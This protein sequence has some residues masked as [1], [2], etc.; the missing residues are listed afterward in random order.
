MD[1]HTREN[2]AVGWRVEGSDVLLRFASF[3]SLK[4][5]CKLYAS[6]VQDRL[7]LFRG[8]RRV[9]VSVESRSSVCPNWYEVVLIARELVA[10]RPWSQQAVLPHGRIKEGIHD[11]ASM[12]PPRSDEG[13]ARFG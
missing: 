8:S 3:C 2:G 1:G 13:W 12:F 5:A 7:R 10:E 11:G 4:G 6:A 9:E